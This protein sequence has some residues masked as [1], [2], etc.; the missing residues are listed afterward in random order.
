LSAFFFFLKL[1]KYLKIK[2]ESDP[3]LIFLVAML[4]IT[5]NIIL[6]PLKKGGALQGIPF[7][8]SEKKKITFAT[9]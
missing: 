7:P 2:E 1:K 5:P 3:F 8:I 9:K 4:R 6:L